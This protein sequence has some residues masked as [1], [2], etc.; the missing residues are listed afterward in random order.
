MSIHEAFRRKAM[1]P[2]AAQTLE[3]TT[4]PAPTRGITLDQNE[5][6]MQPG[7]ALVCDNWKPT[8]KGV[9]LRGGHVLW[10][11]LHAL[12]A[13]AWATAHAYTVGN[14]AYDSVGRTFWNCAVNHTSAATGSFAADRLAH[15]TYWTANAT[16]IR[17]P[18]ISGFQYVSGAIAKIFC[19]QQ[20]KVFDVT[21]TTPV[22]VATGTDGNY[23]ASQLANQGGDW[24]IAVNDAGDPPLRYNG[25]TWTALNAA[26]IV[27]WANNTVYAIGATAKDATDN[28]LWRNTVA[29]TSAA[30]GTFA[31]DRAA[32]V[33]YWVSTAAD[34][35]SWITGPAGTPVAFGNG[36]T[37]VCKYRNRFFFVGLNTMS[38]WYLP[39][40]AVGGALAEIPLSGAATKGGK[41]LFCATWSIDAGDGIDDKIVFMTDQGEIL[42]FTG[43]NPADAANW[44]QEG[45]YTMSPPLGKNAWLGIGGD[46]LVAAVDGILPTSGAITKDRAELELAAITRSIKPMW[47]DEVIAKRAYPW[48]MCK[49]DEYGGI[50]VAMPGAPSGSERCLVVNAATGAWGRFTQWDVQC[51]MRLRGDMFFGTQKGLV[52]QADR[53]GYDDGKPYVATLVGGW[54]VFQSPSQTI[55][56]RQ[57]RASFTARQGEPFQPQLAA[58]TDYV[59][60]IPTPP[61]AGPDPGV[62]DLWDQGLWD[63]AHWDAA[64]PMSP[65]VR[66]TGWVSIG[67]TGFSHAPIVQV[68]VAQTALPLVDLINIAATFERAGINV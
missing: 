40:N 27:N 46:L 1:P 38:A 9:S 57:A 63:V 31:A 67:M 21:T 52:M 32:H 68:T 7:S 50:F 22:L 14:T 43:S 37:Q 29:H 41:L 42:V 58:T 61:I 53:T 6:F 10:T 30:A 18:I 45:R 54:E 28:T 49:W 62:L 20:T 11:D 19:A 24:L 51:C 39:L 25:T 48:T 59:V 47:R 65:V 66:N 55:T 64:A 5:A 4:L 33:G 26:G 34:G 60:N 8:L 15:P 3:T 35:V 16:I 12:D 56:W 44:R 23:S 13:P 2:Q 17:K 36:L